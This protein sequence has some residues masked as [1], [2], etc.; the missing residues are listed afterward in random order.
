MPLV[1][2]VGGLGVCRV[3]EVSL[4]CSPLFCPLGFTVLPWLLI[5]GLQL[6]HQIH[7]LY[8]FLA[9]DSIKESSLLDDSDDTEL[10]LK[11]LLA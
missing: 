11:R 8:S 9:N 2:L 1:L 10:H 4:G 6:I 7:S 3:A 5:G